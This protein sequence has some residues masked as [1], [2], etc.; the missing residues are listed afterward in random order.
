MR[1]QGP[2]QATQTSGFFSWTNASSLINNPLSS[3]WNSSACRCQINLTKW[4]YTAADWSNRKLW[5]S[6]P[7]HSEYL[8]HLFALTLRNETGST[9]FSLRYT[10]SLILSI[11]KRTCRAK[12]RMPHE[13]RSPVWRCSRLGF[14]TSWNKLFHI[15]TCTD[16]TTWTS[17]L[18][19]LIT[20]FYTLRGWSWQAC[21]LF[22]SWPQPAL[23]DSVWLIG[24]VKLRT[25]PV[26]CLK[27]CDHILEYHKARS[28][29]L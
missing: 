5:V 17:L 1:Y 11:Q 14:S 20:N 4:M 26:I 6:H 19:W 21:D 10:S 16:C 23:H 12:N 28:F 8:N 9:T 22:Q 2:T 7:D 13:F 27:Y 3:R 25:L 18:S 15:K 29:L 24:Q